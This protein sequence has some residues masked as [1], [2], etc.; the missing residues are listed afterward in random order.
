MKYSFR[1]S[2]NYEDDH[3]GVPVGVFSGK[4]AILS[5]TSSGIGAVVAGRHRDRRSIVLRQRQR[6][7]AIGKLRDQRDRGTRRTARHRLLGLRPPSSPSEKAGL[8][9]VSDT[10]GRW[11]AACLPSPDPG[12]CRRLPVG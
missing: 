9:W 11:A 1:H 7:R 2:L 8:L 12:G 4:V 3:G 10:G 5:G 6:D